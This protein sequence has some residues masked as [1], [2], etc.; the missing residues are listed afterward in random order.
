M[1]PEISL[2]LQALL[3]VACSPGPDA[4][5]ETP[6]P[7]EEAVHL[8][9]PYLGQMPPGKEPQ[10]FAPGIVSTG[11]AERDLAMTPDGT[12]IY[13]TSVLG[14]GF[15]FSAIVRIRQ[16]DGRWS[17]PEVSAFSVSKSPIVS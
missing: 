5:I 13:F 7:A 9:G 4:S 1:K 17:D 3:L 6:S 12:E 16:I 10:L 8:N 14:A 11:R 2:C 15:N